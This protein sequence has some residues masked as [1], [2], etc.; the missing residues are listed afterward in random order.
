MIGS[1]GPT[2]QTS[3][4]LIMGVTMPWD[5]PRG[6][7]GLMRE[8]HREANTVGQVLH[9]GKDQASREILLLICMVDRCLFDQLLWVELC[10]RYWGHRNKQNREYCPLE[11]TVQ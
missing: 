7:L 2:F 1:G 6:A 4:C 3:L 10:S 9:K 5:L 8:A 11:Q